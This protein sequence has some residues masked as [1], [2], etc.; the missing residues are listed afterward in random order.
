MGMFSKGIAAG[1]A[2][3]TNFLKI[4]ELYTW[5]YGT[6]IKPQRIWERNK[7]I[8]TSFWKTHQETYIIFPSTDA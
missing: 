2:Q 8:R 3:Y 5:I 7:G 6:D 4:T 1:A